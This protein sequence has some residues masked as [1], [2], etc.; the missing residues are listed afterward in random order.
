MM[1]GSIIFP[2]HGASHA[3]SEEEDLSQYETLSLKI[4]SYMCMM[5][6]IDPGISKFYRIIAK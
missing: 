2:T 3:G 6:E 5:Y 4:G 1:V